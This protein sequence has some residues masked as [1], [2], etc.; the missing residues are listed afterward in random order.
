MLAYESA[1]IAEAQEDG[2]P[3]PRRS[4]DPVKRLTNPK[5]VGLPSAIDGS[6]NAR[7]APIKTKRPHAMLNFDYEQIL[8]NSP[9]RLGLT[10]GWPTEALNSTRDDRLLVVP[11]SNRAFGR[12]A[13][14]QD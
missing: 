8:R 14:A 5:E 1:A 9:K 7:A 13:S 6:R 11:C 3:I 12:A 2:A 10:Q 4:Y